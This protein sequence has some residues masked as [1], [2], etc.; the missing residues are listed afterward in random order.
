MK[1]DLVKRYVYAVTCNLPIKTQPEVEK[2]I[3]SMI[4]EMLDARCGN[5]EPSMKDIRAVLT[6]LG[7]PEELAVKYSGDENKALI[8]GI[9]LLWF[10]KILK[11]VLPIAAAGVA[12]A[13]L[14]ASFVHWQQPFEMYDYA[15]DIIGEVISGAINGAA[16]AFVWIT[17][18]FIILERKKVKFNGDEFLSK[19][20]PVPDK[21]ARIKIHEPVINILWHV[22]TVVLFL[23]FPYLMG[24]YSESTGWIPAFN[25]S[26]I[27]ASWY[28]VTLWAAFGIARE[29]VKLLERRYSKRLALTTVVTNILTGIAATLFFVNHSIMNP[30]F[31]EKVT[32][33]IE[34]VAV[35][36][37]GW[38]LGHIYLFILAVMLFALLLDIGVTT[39][40]AIRY[41]K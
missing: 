17:V 3:E 9:Y 10:K 38:A 30:V 28:L 33:M 34:G 4:T 8:S 27:R 13:T 22:A 40:R 36:E 31:V 5:A 15:P 37:I 23:G 16:G 18:I 24:G 6:E 21:R 7:S 32:S 39:F 2:E 29:I 1:N 25:E 19:L 26:Y 12:F 35:N 11:I 14:L 41:E 20:R